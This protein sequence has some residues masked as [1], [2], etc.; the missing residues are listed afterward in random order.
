M[1]PL[2]SIIIPIYNQEKLLAR[3]LDSILMQDYKNLEI[4]LINDGSKDSSPQLCDAY[5]EKDNRI[6]VV[7][8]ENAGVAEARNSGLDV[9]T[10]DYISFID[11]DDWIE[12][13]TYSTLVGELTENDID[14]IRFQAY[15]SNGSI[16]NEIPFDGI[17]TDQTL[18]DFQ[19]AMI[20]SPKF[21]GMFI[22]GVL[23]LH[24]YKRE[25]INKNNIRFDKELR[26]CED[27]LFCIQAILNANKIRFTKH[28]LYHYETSDNSL[29][30]R[31]DPIRWEQ[32]LHFLKELRKA[33]QVKSENFRNEADI[34]IKSDYILRAIVSMNHEFFSQNNN[35][36]SF[37]KKRI[38]QII[39]DENVV[40]SIKNLEKEELGKKGNLIFSLIKSRSA[41]SLTFLLSTILH[42]G[43]LK[44]KLK[45]RNNG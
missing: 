32:E 45:N 38:S 44:N 35:S 14:I 24:I 2:I 25:L 33:Y 8:K 36:F 26:R 9:A 40:I 23:W 42:G 41:L 7:H 34:R 16:L 11:P 6:V 4:I 29:S 37:R 31:Y 5:A 39:N 30:N 18:T 21:G 20:G 15:K 17:Y 10:G 12:S 19:L 1:N 13:N 28:T 27:R 22:L 3:C 43:R